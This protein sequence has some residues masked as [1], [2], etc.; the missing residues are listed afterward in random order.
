MLSIAILWLLLTGLAL[1]LG[2]GFLIWSGYDGQIHHRREDK[3]FAA[4]WLGILLIGS[5][6]E[7]FALFVPLK[8]LGFALLALAGIVVLVS[9]GI[10]GEILDGLRQLPLPAMGMLFVIGLYAAQ[11]VYWFDTG[12]YHAQL[13]KWLGEFG[14]ATGLG[15]WHSRFSFL[16]SWLAF[17]A[18]LEVSVLSG[19]MTTLMGGWALLAACVH[20]LCVLRTIVAGRALAQDVFLGV[21]LGLA[22]PVV[23]AYGMAISPS[24][25][26][27][28]ILLPILVGWLM[29]ALDGRRALVLPFVLA[30]GAA[31]IKL[32][33]LPLLLGATLYFVW[34]DAMPLP[35]RLLMAVSL[36]LLLLLPHLVGVFRASGCLLYPVAVSCADVPWGLG[37][38]DAMRTAAAIT[39]WARWNGAAPAH[40]SLLDWL[41]IWLG[42]G[43]ENQVFACLLLLALL[44]TPLAWRKSSVAQRATLAIAWGGTGFVLWSAPVLRFGLGYLVMVPA[45]AISAVWMGRHP[46][47]S[48]WPRLSQACLWAFALLPLLFMGLHFNPFER[49]YYAALDEGRGPNPDE[50]RFNFLIPPVLHGVVF[51]RS[52]IHKYAIAGMAAPAVTMRNSGG[53]E[54]YSPTG[55][56]DDSCWNAPLPCVP[57]SIDL[58]NRRPTSADFFHAR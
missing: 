37:A 7:V 3:L 40:T 54:V 36:G 29:L 35:R 2:Y 48:E 32:S 19:R 42:F 10:R 18:A 51:V 58:S 33:A 41:K 50:R 39:G 6:L 52:D 34:Q 13:I 38:E 1:S 17:P 53:V 4:L 47:S 15:Q 43:P 24:P 20:G 57:A 44:L 45:L 22:L 27:P 30:L 46:W 25:D 16:S 26:L 56:N 9:R 8:G 28:I 55:A 49:A 11:P 31:T 21:C 14:I 23:L 12:L 5:L